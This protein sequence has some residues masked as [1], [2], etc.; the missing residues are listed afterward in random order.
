MKRKPEQ[1]DSTN[2]TCEDPSFDARVG[3]AFRAE[4]PVP[5][6]MLERLLA[7]VESVN[8][9]SPAD[10]ELKKNDALETAALANSELLA[11]LLVAAD[12]G[13]PGDAVDQ[14]LE[15]NLAGTASCSP[16]EAGGQIANRGRGTW[17]RAISV[18]AAVLVFVV[19]AGGIW[20]AAQPQR[21]SPE[22]LELASVEW[23]DSLPAAPVRDAERASQDREFPLSSDVKR[24][25]RWRDLEQVDTSFGQMLARVT[26]AKSSGNPCFLFTIKPAAGLWFDLPSNLPRSPVMVMREQHYFAASLER[27][28]VQ[29]VVTSSPDDYAEL[30][31]PQA[32]YTSGL[33]SSG[34]HGFQ[35]LLLAD[36]LRISGTASSIG[37]SSSNSQD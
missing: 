32:I 5:A 14:A 13:Q 21:I 18:M 20:W 31:R 22:Q 33:E 23:V 1:L 37:D 12:P 2:E 28:H 17:Q 35:Q 25:Y 34:R 30:L 29:I 10:V 11:D 15:A 36:V 7:H 19:C 16:S 26:D 24:N 6:G 3:Q 27:E 9:S 8:A 4:I